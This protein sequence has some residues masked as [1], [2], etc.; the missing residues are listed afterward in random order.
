MNVTIMPSPY[1]ITILTFIQTISTYVLSALLSIGIFSNIINFILFYQSKFRK[2]ACAVFCSAISVINIFI[3][4]QGFIKILSY[5]VYEIDPE[6]TNLGYCKTSLY[7]RHSMMMVNRTYT[8]FACAASF[9]LSSQKVSIRLLANRIS[10]TYRLIIIFCFSWFTINMYIPFY[11]SIQQNQCT[12]P[13]YYQFIFSIYLF[14]VTDIISPMLMIAFSL[15]T[16]SNLKRLHRRVQPTN[17]NPNISLRLI[18]RDVQLIRMLLIHVAIYMVTTFLYPINML[19]LS[20]SQNAL[21]KSLERT[22]IESFITFYTNY[23]LFYF[24]NIAPFFTYYLTSSTF[25][26][27]CKIIWLKW[28]NQCR[29][30]TLNQQVINF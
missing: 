22:T 25:R 16:L 9:A 3:L 20:I 24:N 17:N 21:T 15:L 4:I 10:L 27:E 6:D 7:L 26:I 2:N 30:R 29:I 5:I 11:K 19:Y 8:V 28:R 1:T 18:K 23:F 12:L 13:N 14:I